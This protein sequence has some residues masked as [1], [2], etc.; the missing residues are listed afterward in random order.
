MAAR[1][2]GPRCSR[3][4][5]VGNVPQVRAASIANATNYNLTHEAW[6]VSP[7]SMGDGIATGAMKDIT[8][9]VQADASLG[10]SGFLLK[11]REVGALYKSRVSGEGR[12][13]AGR[14]V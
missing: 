9:L 4:L 11:L 12:V 2:S 6:L 1:N 5:G 14:R 8:Q 3:C 10:W 7:S 13:P